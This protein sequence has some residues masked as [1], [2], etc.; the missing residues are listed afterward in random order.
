VI[1]RAER[2]RRI[3]PDS[4]LAIVVFTIGILG[5]IRLSH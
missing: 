1:V 4:I 3:G 2:P 5:L